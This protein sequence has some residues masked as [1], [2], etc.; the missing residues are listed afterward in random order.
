M[1]RLI[2]HFS[3]LMI[4]PWKGII[5]AMMTIILSHFAAGAIEGSFIIKWYFWPWLNYPLTVISLLSLFLLSFLWFYENRSTFQ[6]IQVLDTSFITPHR[7]LILLVSGPNKP[8]PDTFPWTLSDDKNN[9]ATIGATTPSLLLN[10][11]KEL[12]KIVYWNWQQILR[13]LYPHRESLEKVILIGSTDDSQK[14]RGSYKYLGQA[15]MLI[16]RYFPNMDIKPLKKAID[17]EDFHSLISCIR[18]EIEKLKDKFSEDDI[19]I[20]VTGGQKTTSIAAA[21]VTMVNHKLK[22][23]YVKTNPGDNED[24][25]VLCFNARFESPAS[26]EV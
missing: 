18:K 24:E 4:L 26:L 15:K 6:S 10:D 12:N 25:N 9:Q 17:F 1:R 14:G 16:D 20:D 7:C 13:G 23:Q 11:I 5:S 19:I 21:S 8:P 2:K 22:F 3:R